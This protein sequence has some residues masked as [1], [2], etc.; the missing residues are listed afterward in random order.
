MLYRASYSPLYV[1]RS[2]K[3]SGDATGLKNV[4]LIIGK[5]S[6][7]RLRA[8][9]GRRPGRGQNHSLLSSHTAGI[10]YA[11]WSPGKMYQNGHW[12]SKFYLEMV[13]VLLVKKTND[14]NGESSLKARHNTT[15]HTGQTSTHDFF[16]WNK[17]SKKCDRAWY[18]QLLD[19]K[20]EDVLLDSLETL[21][22]PNSIHFSWRIWIIYHEKQI[23]GR[24]L[25]WKLSEREKRG[26]V[27]KIKLTG[28]VITT[29]PVILTIDNGHLF[30]DV[31]DR[32]CYK[33]WE[34]DSAK[35][36]QHARRSIC[37][38]STC[39]SRWR[40]GGVRHLADG[41]VI[42]GCW[43]YRDVLDN[44]HRQ[45]S[46]LCIKFPKAQSV[47]YGKYHPVVR[48]CGRHI[49]RYNHHAFDGCII[50]GTQVEVWRSA[51]QNNGSF[52][53]VVFRL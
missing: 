18:F 43:D 12:N 46:T 3:P 26:K 28:H 1:K 42:R 6:G 51:L 8:M 38:S 36:V 16:T 31:L 39:R 9:V 35:Q 10:C 2:W 45:W 44:Y 20:L 41:F 24:R 53:N 11:R 4:R 15:F 25:H 48:G 22:I 32:W 37:W 5:R 34:F 52:N 13:T 19:S 29:T 40:D 27:L 33:A 14:G 49:Y 7:Q 47:L 17:V 30:W 50:V 21:Q 23:C